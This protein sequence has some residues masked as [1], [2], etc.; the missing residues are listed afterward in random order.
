MDNVLQDLKQLPL[1]AVLPDTIIDELA[2]KLV[3]ERY[4]AGHVLFRKDDPGGAMYLIKEGTVEVVLDEIDG[5]ESVLNHCGPGEALG[6]MSLLD[7]APRSASVVTISPAIFYRLTTTEFRN[8]IKDQP[9]DVVEKLKNISVHLRL[10]HLDILR[11]LP[12]FNHLH[13]D[14]LATLV[15][16]LTVS[17]LEPGEAAFRKGDQGDSLYVIQEGWLK[18]VLQDTDGKELILN[19]VGPGE[20]IGEM[21]LLDDEPRSA[22]AI[23]LSPAI[24]LCLS[25]DDFLYAIANQPTLAI[26]VMKGI[27]G[28]LRYATTYI[29]QAIEWSRRIASGDYEFALS[30]IQNDESFNSESHNI[31][32][33]ARAHELLLAFFQMVRGVQERED[34]LKKQVQELIIQIDHGKRKQDVENLT[35]TEF[36]SDLK[37]QAQQLRAQQYDDEE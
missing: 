32:D 30:Q 31:S 17:H 28:R 13:G 15:S 1:M 33:A 21:S 2:G 29:E 27:G 37:T 8:A 9:D 10:G 14:M 16:R 18:I 6:Q 35:N 26:E 25:R 19:K 24:L 20:S 22:S 7:E 34:S 3:E 5:S 36:F 11:K 23:A 4:P 12:L